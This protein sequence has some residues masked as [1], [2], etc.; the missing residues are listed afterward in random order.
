MC[1]L[2]TLVIESAPKGFRDIDGVTQLHIKQEFIGHCYDQFV[3]DSLNRMFSRNQENPNKSLEN[4]VNIVEILTTLRFIFYFR[5]YLPP[6]DLVL[7]VR[8]CTAIRT[9]NDSLK[10]VLTLMVNAMLNLRHGNFLLYK[11]FTFYF[12]ENNIKD[13]A[14]DLLSYISQRNE[15]DS[16]L[17][18]AA[19]RLLHSVL[20]TMKATSADYYDQ[21]IAPLLISMLQKTEQFDFNSV[22]SLFEAIGYL[23]YWLCSAKSPCARSLETTIQQYFQKVIQKESDMINFCFQILS[24]FL[25]L[26][27]GDQ[28]LYDNVY[29][30]VV[31]QENWSEENQSIMSAY[32]QYISAYITINQNKIV[33][34]KRAYE[35]I[36][37]RLIEMDNFELFCRFVKKILKVCGIENFF[38]AG[39]MNV[40]VTG[41]EFISQKSL[42]GRKT[43]LLFIFDICN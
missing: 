43:A 12:N 18:P 9:H 14:Q 16:A 3:K 11:D 20:K 34:D 7:I 19:T 6:Q 8:L 5:I 36:L 40:L 2:L 1:L 28:G 31:R 21:Q 15:E 32:L 33:D 29:A 30:S 38:H 17:N 26:W 39:Y 10:E 25:Q 27:P 37:G 22:L 42:E 24:I 35:A 4:K 41:V 13:V 23:A